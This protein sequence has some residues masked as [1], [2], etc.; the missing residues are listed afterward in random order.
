MEYACGA[1][2]Q[3]LLGL[4]HLA[5]AGYRSEEGEHERA[6]RQLAHARRRLAPLLGERADVDAASLLALV[7]RQVE[8]G[9]GSAPRA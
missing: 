8:P 7:A 1:E 2:R 5:V 9:R 6:R 4:R 3:L